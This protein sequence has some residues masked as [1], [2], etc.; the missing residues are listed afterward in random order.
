M[1]HFVLHFDGSCWPNPGG[2]AAWGF[3]LKEFNRADALP[4]L[5]FKNSGVT[6]TNPVMSNNVAEFDAL[7]YGL[8]YLSAHLEQRVKSGSV[9]PDTLTVYGD[10]QLVVNMMSGIW[11]PKKD[12][13]Y[14]PFWRKAFNAHADLEVLKGLSIDYTWIPREQNTECDDLSKEHNHAPL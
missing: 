11:S 12:K 8:E 1:A 2:T 7:Y 9:E 6:G 5:I 4:R 3:V 13:L 14:Y 10:S